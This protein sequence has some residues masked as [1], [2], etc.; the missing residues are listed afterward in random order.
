MK[1]PDTWF[2]RLSN[3]IFTCLLGVPKLLSLW[4]YI[5][6]KPRCESS[7]KW[8]KHEYHFN[9]ALNYKTVICLGPAVCSECSNA[10]A[11]IDNL[12]FFLR[13]DLHEMTIFMFLQL[14]KMRTLSRACSQH[15]NRKQT[16]VMCTKCTVAQS[17]LP[18]IGQQERLLKAMQKKGNTFTILCQRYLDISINTTKIL[19]Y[20]AKYFS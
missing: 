5:K 7:I 17:T 8:L 9:N 18:L 20:I 15:A 10:Q 6:T 13:E 2:P 1:T 4:S 14:K 3:T 11:V 19:I 12:H 16:C